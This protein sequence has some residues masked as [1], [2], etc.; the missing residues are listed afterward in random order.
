M[1]DP[2][3]KGA[4][5]A[6]Y[7]HLRRQAELLDVIHDTVTVRDLSNRITFWSHGAEQLYGWSSDEAV[8]QVAHHLLRARLPV[9]FEEVRSALHRVGLWQGELIQ[10]RR[11]GA[12]IDVA[13]RWVLRRDETGAPREIV[14]ACHDITGEKQ[15][16]VELAHRTRQLAAAKSFEED[17]LSNLPGGLAYLDRDLVIR[18]IN[19]GFAGLIGRS[20]EDVVG[21]PLALVQEWF[22]RH[23][24]ATLRRVIASGAAQ[25]EFSIPLPPRDEDG[26]RTTYWDATFAPVFDHAGGVK[27]LLILCMDATSRVSLEQEL[28][29]STDSLRDRETLFR[30]ILEASPDSIVLVDGQG[31]ITLA[32]PEA[33]RTFG[34]RQDELIGHTIE[35]LV[36]ERYR[37]EHVSDRQQYSAHARK[38]PMGI[39]MELRARRKDGSELPIEVSL[40]PLGSDGRGQIMAVVRDITERKDAE[41]ALRA[42]EARLADAQRVARVG[43]WEWDLGRDRLVWSDE[44]YRLLGAEPGA[45][46]PTAERFYQ[47]LHPED[48]PRLE[49]VLARVIR[50]KEPFSG[51]FRA[52]HPDGKEVILHARG[53]VVTD[54]HGSPALVV[55]TIQDVTESRSAEQEL[56]RLRRLQRREF[57]LMVRSVKEYAIFMIGPDARILTWN[58][59]ATK[60]TG[61]HEAE[62]LGQPTDILFIPEDV[63]N[64]KPRHMLDEA[65]RQGHHEDEGWRARKGGARYWANVTITAMYDQR[66]RHV[67]FAQ[68]VRDLTQRKTIEEIQGQLKVLQETDRM[69]DEFLSVISHELRTP[70]N[71]ITGF[72]SILEDE[73]AGP[74]TAEQ[75]ACLAKILTGADRMLVLINNLLDMSRIAAGSFTLSPAPTLYQPIVSEV[76]A[77]ME[78]LVAEK[79]QRLTCDV[80][81]PGEVEID[82]QRVIQVLTNLVSNAGKFTPAG[83]AIAIRAYASGGELVTEVSDTGIGI[84][85]EDLPRL[86]RRFMQLD[87]SMTRTVGGSGLGLSICKAIVEAHGG[88]IGVRSEGPGKGSTFWFTL[89]VAARPHEAGPPT[90]PNELPH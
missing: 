7:E 53:R 67:G 1:T 4:D 49:E 38:R 72:A 77:T 56:E 52:A 20:A 75:H 32:N 17:L 26:A 70:L 63:A 11:D 27:G 50:E 3:D 55:G 81:V 31:R 8:G 58:E 2:A 12:R 89:P 74:L 40:S 54:A 18:R 36:P 34:Y 10:F 16:E 78:P 73:V 13:S 82:G 84:A 83:G 39:G 86:F 69:K 79:Q 44:M 88:R 5:R 28:R 66:G 71:F 29:A 42:S 57:E 76:L 87:M 60:A 37:T 62:A 51:D 33:E 59:G 24:L 6:A 43:S 45:F 80:D 22:D 48:R 14:V 23:R 15:A 65:L 64:G 30:G 68:I 25:R 85:T 46:E 41:Q 35:L 47:R 61:Y 19:A 9:P 90:P 21:R